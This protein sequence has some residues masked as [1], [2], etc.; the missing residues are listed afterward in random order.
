MGTV[1]EMPEPGAFAAGSNR[2]GADRGVCTWG[3]GKTSSKT[4]RSN[5]R[6]H[7]AH[8]LR[9]GSGSD[10]ATET[11]APFMGSRLD[12]VTP[13]SEGA[14]L[15][16]TDMMGYLAHRFF[17]TSAVVTVHR[18]LMDACGTDVR[19]LLRD[20]RAARDLAPAPPRAYVE[21]GCQAK[22]EREHAGSAA[23]GW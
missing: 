20:V 15:S 16:A 7:L 21:S 18:T 10:L 17:E 1:T 13:L 8:M 2:S 5:N 22:L 3:W 6:G 9:K 19:P 4:T 14:R 12:E 11:T 23:M